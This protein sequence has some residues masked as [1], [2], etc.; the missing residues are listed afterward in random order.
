[1]P[2]Q[3]LAPLVGGLFGL[4]AGTAGDQAAHAVPDQR[5]AL[6]RM[7]PVPQQRLQ[8]AGELAAVV[9]DRQAAVV[10][11]VERRVAAFGGERGA[12]IEAFVFPLL[13]AH[14]QPVHQHQQLAGRGQGDSVVESGPRIGRVDGPA[15]VPQRHG[16]GERIAGFGQ[17]VAVDAVQHRGEYLASGRRRA[18][19]Q[20]LLERGQGAGDAAATELHPA[21]HVAVDEAGDAARGLFD[22]TA[23]RE[24]EPLHGAVHPLDHVDDARRSVECDLDRAADFGELRAGQSSHGCTP[25]SRSAR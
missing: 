25:V 18:G 5:Q 19:G 7:R 21:A 22:G 3:R 14:A 17:V 15:R 10:A 2:T 20:Q 6:D 9:R 12:V 16:D 11:Q 8:Q 23:E 24:R 1:M 4:E 13:V